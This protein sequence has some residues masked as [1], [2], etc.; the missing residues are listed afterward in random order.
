VL[1]N[2]TWEFSAAPE[3]KAVRTALE[4]RFGPHLNLLP[5]DRGWLTV[6]VRGLTD[7]VLLRTLEREQLQLFGP[8]MNKFQVVC[9]LDA[10]EKGVSIR[11]LP[12]GA[13]TGEP[14]FW[15]Y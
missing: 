14:G 1:K 7:E 13:L 2:I 3:L 15:Y 12:G 4:S 6:Q 8:S 9:R 11:Y 10:K 5:S